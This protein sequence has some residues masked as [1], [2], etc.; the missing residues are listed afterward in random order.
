M[1]EWFTPCCAVDM[2]EEEEA[3]EGAAEGEE[4]EEEEEEAAIGPS[5]GHQGLVLAPEAR[6]GRFLRHPA[7]QG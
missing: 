3:D 7:A 2:A 5:F 4:E 1:G 6:Q